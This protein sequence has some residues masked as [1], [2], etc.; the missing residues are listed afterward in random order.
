M[1]PPHGCDAALRPRGRVVGGPREV[2]EAHRAR[3]RGKGA[4]RPRGSTWAP[5]WGATWQRV[6]KWRA[7]GIVGPSKIV[8]AVTQMCYRT[9]I[10]KHVISKYFFRVG[11]CS[12]TIHFCRLR[13]GREIV[14]CGRDD[15]NHV[16]PSPRDHQWNTCGKY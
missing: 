4:T 15:D 10:F 5:L 16:D 11:L 7:H 13:G 12:H 6:G 8:G 2:Q 9:S 14:G 3:P 1:G